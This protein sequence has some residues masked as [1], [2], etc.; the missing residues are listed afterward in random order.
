[1]LLLAMMHGAAAAW[2][3]DFGEHDRRVHGAA[4]AQ[5]ATAQMDARHLMLTPSRAPTRR[6]SV[7]ADAI[8]AALRRAIAKYQDPLVA[9]ADGFKLFAPRVKRQRIYHYSKLSYAVEATF[10][11][12]PTKPT[13]L[14]YTG[15]P[16]GTMRLI[17]AM[18]TAPRSATLEELDRR[19]PLGIARWHQHINFCI[20]KRG[21]PER[22]R[23]MQDGRPVFG[24][25]SPIATREAC[26]AVGG[27]FLPKVFGWMVHANVFQPDAWADAHRQGK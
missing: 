3:Q 8:A 26:N 16:D 2:A 12:D 14:L 4:D 9:E 1:V 10:R 13:A 15:Q 11:F 17:G 22:W 27:V 20:P 24:P 5:M 6:D 18:Y 19:V 25:L 23:E 7:A 21:E